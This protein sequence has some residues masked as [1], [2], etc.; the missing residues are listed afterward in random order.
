MCI[1]PVN[2]S[3]IRYATAQIIAKRDGKVFMEQIPGIPTEIVLKDGRTLRNAKPRGL[4]RPVIGNIYLLTSGEAEKLFLDVKPEE[5]RQDVAYTKVR[6]ASSEQ[7]NI[8]LG[9]QK[10]AEEPSDEDFDK[11]AVY[12]ISVDANAAS[13][14]RLLRIDYR[15][16]VARLYANGKLV[17]DNFYNGRPFLYGLWRLPAGCTELE[18]RILPLQK[19]MPVYF[20]READTTPGEAVMGMSM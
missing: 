8:T 7:R 3:G 6:E 15:G 13:S 2:I 18:L 4:S 9:V 17:A 19:S 16:D 10:V 14:H 5:A 12:R 1:F 11:A 20:P